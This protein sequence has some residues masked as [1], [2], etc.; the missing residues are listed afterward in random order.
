MDGDGW[1]DL[2]LANDYGPEE[3]FRNLEGRRFE[4]LDDAG[5]AES[6]KS[7]MSV[8]LG[9]FE[10]TGRPGVYVTNISKE[11]F[12]FQGNNLRVNRLAERGKLYNVADVSSSLARAVVDCGWAWGAQFGDLDNDGLLD[13]FVVNG[14][15]SASRERDYW[16]GMSKIAA[17]A[18]EVFA[19]AANW[20]PI[21]DASLSGYERS[22]VL[23]NRG[24]ARFVDVAAAAGVDDE[25]DGR[26]VALADLFGRGALDVVVA[27]QRGP[28]LL[29]ENRVDPGRGWI[30]LRLAGRPPNTSAI[31]AEVRVEFCGRVQVQTVQGGSGFCAQNQRA[32]HF[33]LGD[34]RAV[35]RVAIRWPDGREQ[36]LRAEPGRSALEPGRL[37]VLEEPRP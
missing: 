15:L 18:R 32:L 5:L 8:T 21:G 23:L 4:R 35:E 10:G 30:Q 28:L 37:H 19:D 2:Y 12:L 29:Y 13:L 24:D 33:G 11:R 22:R 17:G 9:D 20:E 1:P 14:F 31:G 27:N 26:A 6:S 7:G 36:E 25:H 34:C 16:Y 3:L